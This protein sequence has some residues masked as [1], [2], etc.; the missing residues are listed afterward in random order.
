[1]RKRLMRRTARSN[2]RLGFALGVALAL[3]LTAVGGPN[4]GPWSE[5]MPV[6]DTDNSVAGGCP[7]E[8]RKGT[9]IY[10]ARAPGGDLDIFVNERDQ[11]GDAFGPATALP[12]PVNSSANDFCPTPLG[13]GFLLFVS[14]RDGG[15]G[16]HPSG[17]IYLTRLN[18]NG[19][20]REPINL[21]CAA[22]GGPNGSG[23]EFSPGIIEAGGKTLL[24]YSSDQASGGQDIFVSEMGADGNFGPGQPVAGLNTALDDRMPT[25][26]K[27]GLEIVFS[28]NR[29]EKVD[30]DGNPFRVQ[31]VYYAQRDS[32]DAPW[33]TP[34]N[35]SESI[36]TSTRDQ[37][38][39]R[40]SFSWDRTRVNYGSA[41]EVYYIERQKL[42]GK[43]R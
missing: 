12:A 33:S 5:N 38:E 9:E 29:L 8:S 36:P 7:I 3:P 24:Y 6:P 14:S 34:V 10:T 27:D 2:Y 18:P 15:C 41:G 37:S 40:A 22:E 39:T 43:N 32:L 23:N 20:W 21:G 25:L 26:T 30:A 4:Y 13:G 28:S 1:M 42:R 16:V 19:T 35:L 17:D 31:D 11:K